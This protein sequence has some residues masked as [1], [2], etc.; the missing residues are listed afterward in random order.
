[1]PNSL[2]CQVYLVSSAVVVESYCDIIGL[3]ESSCRDGVGEYNRKK[4]FRRRV[5]GEGRSDLLLVG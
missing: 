4:G 1:M 2:L 5:H 3:S